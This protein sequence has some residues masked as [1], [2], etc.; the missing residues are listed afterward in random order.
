M[1]TVLLG[2]VSGCCLTGVCEWV[3]SYWGV[4]V[5]AVLLGC[6]SGCCLTGVCEWMLS[7]WGV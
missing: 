3:L 4:L 5:D 6:V 1:G 7:Y 2:C